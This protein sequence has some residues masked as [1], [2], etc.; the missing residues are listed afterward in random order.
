EQKAKEMGK[1]LKDM[2]LGEMDSLWEEAKRSGQAP[3][4]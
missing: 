4:P 2:T 1:E 3:Q